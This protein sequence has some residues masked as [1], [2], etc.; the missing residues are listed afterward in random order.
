MPPVCMQVNQLA[1]TQRIHFHMYSNAEAAHVQSVLLN[2]TS[3][4]F[5]FIQGQLQRKRDR[6]ID[7]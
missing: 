7:S 1:E 4:L 6:L 2:L 3:H 5:L